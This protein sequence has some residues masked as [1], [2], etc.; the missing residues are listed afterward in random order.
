MFDGWATKSCCF[1]FRFLP[2]IPNCGSSAQ[3]AT[4]GWATRRRPSRIWRRPR[5]CATITAPLSWSS[6]CSTTARENTTSPSSEFIREI[7][8]S[9]LCQTEHFCHYPVLFLCFLMYSSFCVSPSLSATSVSVWSWT[10]MTRNVSVTTSRWR[11][12]ASSW[13]Q[14][15]SWFRRRGGCLRDCYTCSSPSTKP[16]PLQWTINTLKSLRKKNCWRR[17]S[18]S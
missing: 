12:S 14:Q 6:V 17:R 18:Y 9:K 8:C 11:S 3:S 7:S 4:S 1:G 10:R 16:L 13:I 5:G 2:G 15:R